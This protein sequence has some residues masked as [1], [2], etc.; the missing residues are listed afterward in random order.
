MEYGIN[1]LWPTPVLLDKMSN[2]ELVGNVCQ[3]LFSDT[4]LLSPPSDFQNYDVLKDGGEIFKEFQKVVV[5][6]AFDNYLKKILG[7]PLTRYKRFKLRSWIAGSSIGYMIPPHNHSGATLS[8]VFYLL[9]EEQ[10]AGGEFIMMDPRSNAVRGYDDNF[11]PLFA[12]K[13]L[14]P[15]TG[16]VIVMPSYA[17]H[18][19]LPF[20]GK[21]RLAMPVDFYP[22]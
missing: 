16:D 2:D 19:T 1:N 5:E 11:K 6:P 17:Y 15:K 8:A 14:T 22:G 13:R 12:E 9:C 10:D 20:R 3:T 4:D 21:M 7:L 18:Y